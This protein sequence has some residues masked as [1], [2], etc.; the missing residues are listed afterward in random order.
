M[1][2]QERTR[3]PTTT[4]AVATRDAG[5]AVE[6]RGDA[7]GQE[8]TARIPPG[9]IGGA[10]LVPPVVM[11]LQRN[12]GN[13]GVTALVESVRA[14]ERSGDRARRRGEKQSEG[15]TAMLGERA[16]VARVERRR[17]AVQRDF[18]DDI[19]D[20]VSGT[21]D[22]VADTASE[23]ADTVSETA[24]EAWDTATET[25]GAVADV[26]GTVAGD[27][28]DVAS[29]VAGTVADTAGQAWETVTETASGVADAVA[30]GA[31]AAWDEAGD[32]A[33][34]V[35]DGVT[36]MAGR[37]WDGLAD[38]A[39]DVASGVSG[40]AGDVW[41]AVADG[42]EQVWNGVQG[43]AGAAWDAVSDAASG[44]WDA[45]T[46]TA[47]ELADS[48]RDLAAQ[49][50]NELKSA[51]G[52]AWDAVTG[53]IGSLW[54]SILDGVGKALEGLAQNVPVPGSDV[55]SRGLTDGERS[56]ARTVF[57]DA[58]DLDV[59]VVTRGSLLAAGTDRTTGNTVN[60]GDADFVDDTMDLTATGV[61]Y[62]IHELTHV[63]QFQQG[64]L[65]YIPESLWDQ[66]ISK[67]RTGSVD[68]AYDW[69]PLDAAGVPWDEWHVE[70]QA[71]AVEDYNREL[72]KIDRRE[73]YDPA[74]IARLQKYVDKMRAGPRS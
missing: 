51:A 42:A 67:I 53:A 14:G 31:Q 25:A 48:V 6:A 55:R 29:D 64:G 30:G 33:G 38:T 56:Q 70:P 18:L 73:R 17:R 15:R 21:V 28:V 26:A 59:V 52:A 41:N 45:V 36:D 54:N 20:A 9:S 35:V 65:G 12:A 46:S 37:A 13:R 27:V 43:A 39:R 24:G 7:V 74:L 23:V 60:L 63:M 47:S 66:L 22:A 62:L 2:L 49:A 68:A 32:V 72:M 57:G 8:A 5:E 4:P 11:R 1:Y 19:G 16:A 71:Q 69:R 50:W 44:A 34:Q 3:R 10:A 61:A 40:V 58:I